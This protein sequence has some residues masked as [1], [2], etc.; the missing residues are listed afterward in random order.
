LAAVG[1]LKFGCIF[2]GGVG[3]FVLWVPQP[4]CGGGGGGGSYH[5]PLGWAAGR[6]RVGWS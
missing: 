2:R 3:S 4:P 6:G 5:L 1:V